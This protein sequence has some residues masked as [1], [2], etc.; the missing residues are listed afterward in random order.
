VASC[1]VRHP[2]CAREV[3]ARQ[4]QVVAGGRFQPLCN[5]A[6]LLLSK[7]ITIDKQQSAN[8]ADRCFQPMRLT[9]G[10]SAFWQGGGGF[11]MLLPEPATLDCNG[12]FYSKVP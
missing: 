4:L 3:L 11:R 1:T 5:I 10:N 2:E 7:A 8:C 12:G 9:F 6:L